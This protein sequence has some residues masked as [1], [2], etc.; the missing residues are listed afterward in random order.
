MG[1]KAL[2]D[3]EVDFDFKEWEAI[4]KAEAEKEAKIAKAKAAASKLQGI[5][6]KIDTDGNYLIE[7]D[8][9]VKAMKET[10]VSDAD[11]DD[12]FKAID[13]TKS[14]SLSMAEFK[15]FLSKMEKEA[16]DCVE[17]SATAKYVALLTK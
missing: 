9:F 2:K 6:K 16:E 10:G 12:M 3:S 15:G 7:K 5:F 11:A 8:E 17:D 4:L 14:G 1:T 13:L